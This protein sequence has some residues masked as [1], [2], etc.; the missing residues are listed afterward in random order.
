MATSLIARP[1]TELGPCV[2]ADCVHTDCLEMRTIAATS[3]G[4][5]RKPIGYEARFYEDSEHSFVH[6]TCLE[7]KYCTE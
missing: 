1:G 4:L 2:S 5:C 7:D 3:C 6:A